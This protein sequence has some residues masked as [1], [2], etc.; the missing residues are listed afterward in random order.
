MKKR[1]N[2]K[3]KPYLIGITG[4]F[5]AGKSF[6]GDILCKR[7]I[8]VIDSD[9]IV[10]KT[11]SKKN[12]ITKKIINEFGA[13]VISANPGSYISKKALGNI[14]FKNTF[15]R[16]KLES[17]IHPE[18]VAQIKKY[19]STNKKKAIIAVLIPLL[20]E[21]KLENLFHEIW[22]VTCSQNVRLERLKRKGFLLEDIKARTK[23]QFSQKKKAILSDYVIDN[24]GSYSKAKKQIFD[25][26]KL[27]VQSSRNSHPFDG[28]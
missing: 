10:R 7:G 15:K 28:K 9:D 11:L 16:K 27:V 3:Q 22:C 8:L 24:S 17:I 2:F 26:L 5:G 13:C 21:A 20:F 6:V 4:S 14:V 1:N 12:P 23:A 25:R 19:I 18:V